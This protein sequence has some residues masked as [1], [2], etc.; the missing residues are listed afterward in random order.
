M[1]KRVVIGLILVN[2]ILA[3]AIMIGP[4][5]AQILPMGLRDCCENGACC[6]GCCWLVENCNANGDCELP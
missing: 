4:V 1:R 6:D 5:G 3:A 2:V